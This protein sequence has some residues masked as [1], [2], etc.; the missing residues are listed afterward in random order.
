MS[1][2]L[3]PEFALVCYRQQGPH[4][5]CQTPVSR[6]LPELCCLLTSHIP[7]RTTDEGSVTQYSGDFRPPFSVCGV[8][9]A[10][11]I[12]L[13]K[14]HTRKLVIVRAYLAVFVC[15]STNA[16]HLEVVSDLT[17]EAFLACLR[18]FVSRHGLPANIH[19]DNG[20]NFRGANNDLRELYILL[21]KNST[22]STIQSY[23][24][25][26]TMQWYFSPERAPHF[27]GMWEAA[28]KSAKRHLKRVIGT[29]RL[30]FEEFL[31]ITSQVES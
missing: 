31:T 21:E 29:Q 30:D 11:P 7:N 4:P 27:G 24:L 1:R 23:L 12:L 9:Y 26:Q 8:D 5:R 6:C 2:P 22:Q 15:F 3:W 28:L 17:T 19:S 25:S 13:K 14:G 16:A 10:G 18:R 20:G